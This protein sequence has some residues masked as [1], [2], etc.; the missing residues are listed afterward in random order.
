M[1]PAARTRKVRPSTRRVTSACAVPPRRFVP[2][3]PTTTA[4]VAQSRTSSARGDGRTSQTSARAG[5]ARRSGHFGR[6]FGGGCGHAR[7]LARLGELGEVVQRQPGGGVVRLGPRRRRRDER[8]EGNE[9]REVEGEHLTR[10]CEQRLDGR[11]LVDV[12]GEREPGCGVVRVS[13]RR[14]HRPDGPGPGP[15][16]AGM[17]SGQRRDRRERVQ[18]GR[19]RQPCVRVVRLGA[20][21]RRLDR[22]RHVRRQRAFARS[23]SRPRSGDPAGAAVVLGDRVPPP[24]VCPRTPPGPWGPAGGSGD[25]S[26]PTRATSTS[27]PRRCVAAGQRT[28]SNTAAAFAVVAAAT[29][30]ASSPRAPATA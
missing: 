25:A 6:G 23:Y 7:Q 8:L 15:S 2:P 20:R 28:K 1:G 21:R 26:G 17:A 16:R 27:A 24:V 11:Q 5:R 4:R 30:A 19:E 22:A 29:S 13:P 12:L 9:C 18:V 10:R 14:R 3:R